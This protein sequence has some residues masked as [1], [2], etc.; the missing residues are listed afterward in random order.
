[1]PPFQKILTAG[2]RDMDYNSHMAN[3]AY[4]DRAADVRRISS[5]MLE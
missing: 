2:W 3:T 4:L 5:R 1:M